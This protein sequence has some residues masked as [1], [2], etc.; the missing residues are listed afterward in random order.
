MSRVGSVEMRSYLKH[1]PQVQEYLRSLES[2]QETW[3][4]LALLSQM[5]G[6]G[7][8]LAETRKAFEAL[9]GE[10]VSHLTSETL[11]KAAADLG[12][13]AQVAI[14]V[15]VRNLFERTAD[16]GFL[17][18]DDDILRFMLERDEAGTADAAATQ[19]RER[20]REYT[21]KYSV[22]RN[23][24]LLAPDGRVLVQLEAGNACERSADPLVARTLDSTSA[25]VE[26]FGAS[27]LA[28]GGEPVLVY[29]H[30]VEQQQRA[31]GVLALVFRFED[32][33]RAIFDKLRSGDADWTVFVLL[34]ERRRVIAS[35]D[36][37][38]LPI[39]APL[40]VAPAEGGVVR[41]A[42]REYLAATRATVGYQGYMGPAGWSGQALL[43]LE[44]AFN[45]PSGAMAG[46]DPQLLA[47]THRGANVF[48]PELRAIPARADRI[49]RDLNRS[50]WNGNLQRDTQ[51]EGRSFS[52][53]LL[54]EISATGRRTQELF[55]RSIGELQQTVVSSMLQDGCFRA[56]LAADILDR[57]LYERANDCRWWAL[58]GM[59]RACL[60][61]KA[62]VAAATRI[63]ERINA[64]YTVYDHILL[65][66][67]ERRV[68]AVSRPARGK[69]VG[70]QLG[71][72]WAAATL[73][74]RDS[75]AWAVSRFEPLE[76]YEGRPTWVFTAAVRGSD[77]GTCG[78]IAIV[79]DA[80]VQV[81]AM[82]R[83]VLPHGDGGVASGDTIAMFIDGE[84][85]VIAATSGFSSGEQVP[86]PAHL[87][88]PDGAGA[89]DIVELADG[90]HA[91]GTRRCCGYREFPGLAITAVMLRR[92]GDLR[93]G[94]AEVLP[95]LQFDTRGAPAG[96]ASRV[97]TFACAGQW[98]A[99]PA[100]HVIEAVDADRIT[101]M[102]GGSSWYSGV[103]RFDDGVIPVI[104]LA[105]WNG[106]MASATSSTIMVVRDGAMR[107]GLLIDQL[108]D[109]LEI[110]AEDLV[111]VPLHG[112]S[113]S[114]TG[115][116]GRHVVKL[117]EAQ[118]GM[119][120]VVDIA[121]LAV[122]LRN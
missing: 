65:F 39:G 93:T 41:F 74:L 45:Q 52:G 29:S 7:T 48:S 61:G 101:R 11:R 109:V 80:A 16:I 63:L 37:W 51:D 85:R 104:D 116:T 55:A 111:E 4:H 57:N 5:T 59:L 8:S 24:V 113:E 18:L 35:S 36:P 68:V 31:L 1:M 94:S 86:L 99:A 70:R 77:G 112:Q 79:F 3:A 118:D 22:Y 40:P 46:I 28:H 100:D 15:L 42:G 75:Q 72:E 78:G 14:D 115:A 121:A 71:Q 108:G 87:L 21:A 114:A 17:S 49:Q 95:H 110:G 12:A 9:S 25:Y 91:A 122:R 54:H 82:L 106:A 43:P 84:G 97:A 92:L 27:D 23:V 33:M 76:Q 44:H 62:E 83:D 47:A 13:R 56:S 38:Q 96:R 69:I 67:R 10:L 98:L 50:V 73:Q 88:Q 53:V 107:F 64:L 30:R 6:G 90:Y 119:L 19:L 20:F 105:R 2:L 34:D 58:N 120:P 60:E 89:A 103:V 81:E 66:D 26:T 32:E 117:G 102:P